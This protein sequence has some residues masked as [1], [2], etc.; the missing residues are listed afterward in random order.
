MADSVEKVLAAV[1]PNFLRAAGAF[2]AVGHGGPHQAE[3]NLSA[4]FFFA[5]RARSQEKSETAREFCIGSIWASKD[6]RPPLLPPG[7][8]P[9]EARFR[10]RLK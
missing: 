9:F 7:P 6:A 10:E 4:T 1:G 8:S 2:Y 5:L 3:Q